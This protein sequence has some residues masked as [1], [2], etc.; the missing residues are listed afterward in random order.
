MAMGARPRVPK[1]G[2]GWDFPRLGWGQDLL[3]RGWGVPSG[4]TSC[5][6]HPGADED[7]RRPGSRPKPDPKPPGPPRDSGGHDWY[8]LRSGS[9]C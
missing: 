4:L 6:A 7:P 2:L 1:T 5:P 3:G 8:R 9:T